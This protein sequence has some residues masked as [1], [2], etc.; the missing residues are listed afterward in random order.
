[1][2]LC[3][4][5]DEG[6]FSG[7]DPGTRHCLVDTMVLLQMRQGDPDVIGDAKRELRGAT[8]VLL[9]IIVV[10]AVHRHGKQDGGHGMAD[11]KI[12]CLVPVG[13]AQVQRHQVQARAGGTGHV[14]FRATDAL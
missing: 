2:P 5:C 9:D 8:L 4:K 12:F 14:C 1:M 3:M 7:L 10:E 13:P 6:G 11:P